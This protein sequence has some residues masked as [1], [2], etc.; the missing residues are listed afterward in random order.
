MPK[1]E[2]SSSLWSLLRRAPELVELQRRYD[3]PNYSLGA[4]EAREKQLRGAGKAAPELT[5]W[6]D[7]LPYYRSGPRALAERAHAG[8]ALAAAGLIEPASARQHVGGEQ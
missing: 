6:L 5:Q 7:G 3:L 4:L 2:H 1:E 8:A